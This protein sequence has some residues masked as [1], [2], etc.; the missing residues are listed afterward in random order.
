MVKMIVQNP[1]KATVTNRENYGFTRLA[2]VPSQ[3][4][5]VVGGIEMGNPGLREGQWRSELF[6][7]RPLPAY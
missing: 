1:T 2:S 5:P 3:R 4:R 7:R 6:W